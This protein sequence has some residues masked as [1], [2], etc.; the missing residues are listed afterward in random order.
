MACLAMSGMGWSGSATE[1]SEEMQYK[2][3]IHL[4]ILFIKS[5]LISIIVYVNT[6]CKSEHAPPS[7]YNANSAHTAH[8]MN[9]F[10][11]HS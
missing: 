4:I 6:Y 8:I 5:F 9:A 2:F 7:I 10:F 3:F 11:T 1:A